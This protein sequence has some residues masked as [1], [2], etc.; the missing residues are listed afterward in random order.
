MCGMGGMG[1]C[2]VWE[3]VWYVS[4]VWYVWYVSYVWYVRY[5]SM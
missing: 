3:Y 5:V 2:V 4:Y 1:V